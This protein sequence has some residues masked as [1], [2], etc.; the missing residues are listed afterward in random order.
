MVSHQ[1]YVAGWLNSSV[2]SF[3]ATF[4]SAS[5]TMMYAL[6]TC[7]DSN[8]EP[9]KL[10][11]EDETFASLIRHGVRLGQGVLVPTRELLRDANYKKIFF[12]FDEVW[13]FPTSQIEPKPQSAWLIGPARINETKLSRLSEWMNTSNCS[14]AMGDGE[15][16]NFILKVR[17]IVKYVLGH[18]IDQPAPYMA[19]E[20][21]T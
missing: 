12:G 10:L 2:S 8:L 9:G 17:G 21:C 20:A 16:L 13:F 4:P 7:L 14:L 1:D 11:E 15:G 18:S 5:K 19:V 3:F 6:I